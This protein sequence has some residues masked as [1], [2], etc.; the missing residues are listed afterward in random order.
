MSTTR[1]LL[2]L[3][4]TYRGPCLDE[5]MRHGYRASVPGRHVFCRQHSSHRVTPGRTRC[6]FIC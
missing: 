6:A 4:E 2:V 5:Y 3:E 1:L